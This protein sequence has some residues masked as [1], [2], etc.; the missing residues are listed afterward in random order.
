MNA[1]AKMNKLLVNH[2][3]DNKEGSMNDHYATMDRR[4][5]LVRAGKAG[6]AA[7]LVVS[8]PLLASGWDPAKA[9]DTARVKA[10]VASHVERAANPPFSF[11]YGGN[12]APALL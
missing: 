1:A 9:R 3:D 4:N 12:A 11:L 8:L 7:R 2:P 10:F 5:Y 6:A